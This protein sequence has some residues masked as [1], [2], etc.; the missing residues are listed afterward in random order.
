[1]TK[2]KFQEI[3]MVMEANQQLMTRILLKKFTYTF[4]K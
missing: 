2:R 3:N 1:M 4:N